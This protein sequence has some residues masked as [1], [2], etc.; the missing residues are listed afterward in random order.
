MKKLLLIATVALVSLLLLAGGGR[1]TQQGAGAGERDPQEGEPTLVEL[2]FV[3]YAAPADAG[4]P[5][6]A[7]RESPSF[8][9]FK[10]FKEPARW[11][12]GGAVKY[13]V[14]DPVGVSTATDAD[15]AAEAAGDTLNGFITTRAITRDDGSPTTN[16]CTA[17]PNTVKWT[18]LTATGP[19][20]IAVV[21]V[22][23][24]LLPSGQFVAGDIVGFQ[25]EF[26]SNAAVPWTTD[27]SVAGEGAKFDVENAAAHEFAHVGG[28]DHV[29]Q[30]KDDC[31][32]MF[33]TASAGETQKRTLGRGDKLGLNALYTTGDTE[34]G[35]GCGG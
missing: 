24:F 4:P 9:L 26:N 1:N 13:R 34:P 30:L 22:S 15:D 20:G 25:I 28:L 35:P 10:A 18:D 23:G 29:D 31:L 5:G 12:S 8:R 2:V 3:D 27:P 16:P 21:C 7:Q 14:I 17:A 33:V 19:L 32:T 11:P 6:F